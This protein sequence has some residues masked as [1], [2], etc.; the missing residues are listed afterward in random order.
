MSEQD[1]QKFRAA[2]IAGVHKHFPGEPKPGYVAPWEDTPE[3][4]RQ[5]AAKTFGLVRQHIADSPAET[6]R[7]AKGRVVA[8]LWQL[9][10]IDHFG[11]SKPAYTAEWDALPEWQREVDAD[12]YDVV[13]EG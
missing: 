2:W 12:I 10:M 5:A 11:D 6:D 1:G 8:S 13:A 7:E 4:E 3:W 9:Q